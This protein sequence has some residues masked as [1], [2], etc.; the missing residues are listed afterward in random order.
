MNLPDRTDLPFFSYGVFKPGQL[1]FFRLRDFVK[2]FE[3]NSSIRGRLLERDGLPIAAV[4]DGSRVKGALIFF[5]AGKSAVA[6][7]RIVEVEPD[8][9]YRWG[10]TRA[11]TSKGVE[12]A[13]Y[14]LGRSPRK[15]S[16]PLEKDEWDGRED[17]LFTSALEVVEETCQQNSEFEWNLKPLFRLQMAYLL[18]WSSIERYV[19]LRYHLGGKVAEKVKQLADEKAFCTSL[20]REVSEQREIYRADRPT[21]KYKLDPSEPAQSLWYYYQVRSNITHRGKAVTRD[22]RILRSCSKTTSH[23]CPLS[24]RRQPMIEITGKGAKC[25]PTH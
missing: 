10:I 9:H 19:A 13:N 5:Q 11:K 22:F 2:Y 23:F 17:P 14:L 16:V 7:R 8:K 21:E 15:G 18:L 6:Y 4:G 3:P 24:A 25:V 20:E 1:G 12:E